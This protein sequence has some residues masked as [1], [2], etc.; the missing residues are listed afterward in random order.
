MINNLPEKWRKP[1]LEAK[2]QL[3]VIAGALA[4]IAIVAVIANL[5]NKPPPAKPISAAQAKPA[6]QFNA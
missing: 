3:L 6:P 4:A 5:E 1:L 2:R